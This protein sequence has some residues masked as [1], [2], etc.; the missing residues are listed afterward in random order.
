M[1]TLNKMN[2]TD[3]YFFG[4]PSIFDLKRGSFVTNNSK[5]AYCR[6]GTI[7]TL[8]V[9]NRRLLT[10]E[11]DEHFQ[12]RNP[13]LKGKIQN[14]SKEDVQI[15]L[16]PLD[17]LKQE[18]DSFRKES[19]PF[20][21]GCLFQKQF[22]VP[23]EVNNKPTVDTFDST[24]TYDDSFDSLKGDHDEGSEKTLDDLKSDGSNE[25]EDEERQKCFD[26]PEH[27][28]QRKKK[29]AS[30][31]PK[32]LKKMDDH[33]E[34][35]MH[36]FLKGMSNT[37]PYFMKGQGKLKKL[38]H[39]MKRYKLFLPLFAIPLASFVLKM[40]Y[41]IAKGTLPSSYLLFASYSAIFLSCVAA[42]LAL[43][44]L[45]KIVKIYYIDHAYKKFNNSII[46]IQILQPKRE[47]LII[48]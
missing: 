10:E 15:F 43:Y 27:P 22:E 4:L 17:E 32:F 1:F 24:S 46:G 29:P 13:S 26:P 11:A 41:R 48:L 18:D 7:V 25:T 39:S 19:N 33:F 16:L 45:Y 3:F 9:R 44:Y 5:E 20:I 30:I 12:E 35:E 31:M 6:K 21:T 47:D 8:G 37:N 38:S 2:I 23:K 14:L 40:I 36:Q 28:S 34:F 42:I